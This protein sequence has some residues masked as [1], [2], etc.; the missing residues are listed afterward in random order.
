MIGSGAC[1]SVHALEKLTQ[2]NSC[3][4][5]EDSHYV[6]KLA[7]IP[8][9]AGG[10]AKKKKKKKTLQERNADTLFHEYSLYRNVLHHLRGKSVPDLPVSAGVPCYGENSERGFRYLVMERMACPVDDGRVLA[11]MDKNAGKGA[12][13]KMC[14]NMLDHLERLHEANLIF[15]DVKP[16]NFM[17]ARS[18]DFEKKGVTPSDIRLIDLGI[19]ESF[20]DRAKHGH[21]D[22][23][24]G[25]MVGTPAYVSLN[26]HES[27]TPSRRDDIESLGYVVCKLLLLKNL[28]TTDAIL[29]WEN[30]NS[31]EAVFKQK[32]VC[33][34]DI[35]S[36]LYSTMAKKDQN[37]MFQFFDI[38]EKMSYDTKPDYEK[39]K[40]LLL[41]L[42]GSKGDSTLKAASKRK[43]R[44]S[45]IEPVTPVRPSRRKDEKKAVIEVDSDED[46]SLEPPTPAV[47]F[48]RQGLRT[49]TDNNV[50]IGSNTA[51]EP[52]I[53]VRKQISQKKD[54]INIESDSDDES[55]KTALVRMDSQATEKENIETSNTQDRPVA[56]LVVIDGPLVGQ[57]LDVYKTDSEIVIGRNPKAKSKRFKNDEIIYWTLAE[58][59]S[60]SSTHVSLKK[61]VSKYSDSAVSFS[62][63]DL[64]STNGTFINDR[65]IYR[66]KRIFAGEH[67]TIGLTTIKV[68]K[69]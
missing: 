8:V 46:L 43:A 51:I 62:V 68:K 44:L 66:P 63:T 56:R 17:F 21:R 57:A 2:K 15:I 11:N 32:K 33:R 60:M 14:A 26:I 45:P 36:A 58:D 24:G 31:D 10:A 30:S 64:E 65:E 59:S 23:V 35:S 27:H 67:V 61:Y 13:G 47:T 38:C 28:S 69:S 37:T 54:V 1:G 55:F 25:G 18:E 6:V 42:V 9:Q 53:H 48:R 12:F 4:Y 19:A 22:D 29:P 3:S 34:D 40:N 41:S 39:M 5:T 50:K 52:C 16:E 49:K 20:I 7:S